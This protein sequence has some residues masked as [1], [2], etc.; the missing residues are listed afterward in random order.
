MTASEGV[1]HVVAEEIA[2]NAKTVT[3]Y[4]NVLTNY[5]NTPASLLNVADPNHQIDTQPEPEPSDP[6]PEPV[7]DARK[8][9]RLR[10]YLQVYGTKPK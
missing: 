3:N 5:R 7:V 1:A 10:N 8:V 6:A 2:V 4:W 9:E